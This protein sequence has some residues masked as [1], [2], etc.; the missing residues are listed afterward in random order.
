[1][2]NVITSPFGSTLSI[3]YNKKTLATIVVDSSNYHKYLFETI[4][5]G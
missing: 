4:T 2:C 5:G 1:V 3:V